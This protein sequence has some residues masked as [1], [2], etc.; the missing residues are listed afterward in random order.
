M[1]PGEI[2]MQGPT[3]T[4]GYFKRPEA[5][6]AAFTADGWFRSGDLGTLTAD[7]EFATWRARTRSSASAARTWRRPRSSRCCA[8]HTGLKQMCVLGVPDERLDEV[9]AAIVAGVRQRAT[10]RQVLDKLRVATRRIQ[11]AAAGLRHRRDA[12]DG[13]Q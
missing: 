12:D 13:H 2:Q 3:M 11:D 8:T 9:A 4:P 6:A 7:G 5:T 10:G 1:Q